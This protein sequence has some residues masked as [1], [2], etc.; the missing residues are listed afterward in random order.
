MSCCKRPRS[1]A[2]C[3]ADSHLLGVIMDPDSIPLY[4]DF[5]FRLRQPEGSS[6][7]YD[8]RCSIQ[9]DSIQRGCFLVFLLR[10]KETIFRSPPAD[11]SLSIVGK[12]G[13]TCLFLNQ[14]LARDL[15]DWLRLVIRGWR[16]YWRLNQ[17]D[18]LQWPLV[19]YMELAVLFLTKRCVCL[20]NG[21]FSHEDGLANGECFKIHS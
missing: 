6:Y 21:C 13:N 7:T 9:N 4:A 2:T 20:T 16:T 3:S 1:I 19:K 18:H 5:I 17:C 10:M 14:W 12:D 8:F 15:H 11:F